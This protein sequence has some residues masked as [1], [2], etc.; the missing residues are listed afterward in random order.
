[1]DYCEF[2]QENIT[3]ALKSKN[4]TINKKNNKKAARSTEKGKRNSENQEI[5]KAV[6]C[7]RI[8]NMCKG[9]STAAN[10]SVC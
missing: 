10:P 7:Q 5:I 1:M 6:S 4:G 8:R 2:M 9:P 3:G